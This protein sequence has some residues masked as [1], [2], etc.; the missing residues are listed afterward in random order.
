MLTPSFIKKCSTW[1]SPRPC[2]DEEAMALN[3]LRDRASPVQ[4]QTFP[5]SN[6]PWKRQ[7][8]LQ[9]IQPT[10]QFQLSMPAWGNESLPTHCTLWFYATVHLMNLFQLTVTLSLT[11]LLAKLFTYKEQQQRH[12]GNSGSAMLFLRC[13]SCVCRILVCHVSIIS[14]DSTL[15]FTGTRRQIPGAINTQPSSWWRMNSPFYCLW[16]EGCL[17]QGE[18]NNNLR[19][20]EIFISVFPK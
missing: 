10:A 7:R 8:Q 2:G 14:C 18:Q 20:E 4:Q 15:H 11:S 17:L 12:P 13:L 19:V 3:H 9:Q 16:L 6:H 1:R 5:C